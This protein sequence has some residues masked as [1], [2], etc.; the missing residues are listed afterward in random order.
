MSLLSA[1]MPLSFCVTM[2]VIYLLLPSIMMILNN[3]K[4]HDTTN[5]INFTNFL[6]TAGTKFPKK[7]EKSISSTFVD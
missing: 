7:I 6:P 3:F 4:V 5:F 1:I 2:D